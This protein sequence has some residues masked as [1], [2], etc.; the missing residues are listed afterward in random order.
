[1][2]RNLDDVLLIFGS[3]LVVIGM[4]LIYMPAGVITAGLILI[5]FGYLVGKKMANDG[6]AE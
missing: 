2:K 1:M 6:I 3:V 4:G 5:G